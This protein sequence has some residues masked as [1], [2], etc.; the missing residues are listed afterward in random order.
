MKKTVIILLTLLILTSCKGQEKRNENII[1]NELKYEDLGDTTFSL[2]GQVSI[3]DCKP[4][5][6]KNFRIYLR[7]NPKD[8]IHKQD[9]SFLTIGVKGDSINQ[10]H[11][12]FP[13]FFPAYIEINK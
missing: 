7:T 1:D 13:H 3:L 11:I 8:D 2:G 12:S 4:T 6:D 10:I 5:I 9:Y